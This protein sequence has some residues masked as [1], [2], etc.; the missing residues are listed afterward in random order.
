MLLSIIIVAKNEEKNIARCIESILNC[1]K[2]IKEKEILLVDSSSSDKTVEIA[3]NYPINIISL[4][5]N[6]QL[7]PSAARF[8]GVNNV[9]GKYILIIDGDMELLEGFIGPALAFM[10][11]NNKVAAVLGKNYDIYMQ[12]DGICSKPQPRVKYR[13]YLNSLNEPKKIN[14]VFGSSIFRREFLLK[15]GNFH[16]YLR[17]EEEAE[18]SSRLTKKG[19]DLFFLPYDHAYHYSL[20]KTTFKE[21]ARRVKNKLWAGMGDA[22]GLSFRQKRY[23]FIYQRYRWYLCFAGFML[24]SIIGILYCLFFKRYIKCLVFS[25]MLPSFILLMCIKKKNFYQGILST[26]NITIVSLNI[27]TGLFRKLKDISTY[28]TDVNWIKKL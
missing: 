3:K 21:T 8:N 19:Y 15:V 14:F 12:K 9:I 1:T 27:F 16:P 6:W 2:K 26:L 10:G 25:S 28:P 22:I 23:L 7:S 24:V 13:A 20:P 18:L 17:A 4:K 11:K 5:Q